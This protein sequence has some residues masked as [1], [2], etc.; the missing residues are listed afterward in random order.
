MNAKTKDETEG[1]VSLSQMTRAVQE[2]EHLIREG[3]IEGLPPY[4]AKIFLN[5]LMGVEIRYQ[6]MLEIKGLIELGIRDGLTGLYNKRFFGEQLR[7]TLANTS[8][9][10]QPLCLIFVDI[11][12]FK[13]RVN[14]QHGHPNGD[15]VLTEVA[16]VLGSCLSRGS[17]I[18]ARAGGEE[19]GFILPN[20][21]WEKGI[22]VAERIR[23]AVEKKGITLLNNGR[24]AVTVSVGVANFTPGKQG[25]IIPPEELTFQADVA[26]YNAKLERNQVVSFQQGMSI[27]ETV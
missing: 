7:I 3:M 17:D 6:S 23:Q 9:F 19:F 15:V 22:K 8:R 5:S 20:T 11:D 2:F 10:M 26:L 18:L 14:D 12:Y 16:K 13:T 21:S 24:I 4:L 1:F 27:P 25:D